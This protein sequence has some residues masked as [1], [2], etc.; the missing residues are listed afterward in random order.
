[1]IG[2]YIGIVGVLIGIVGG[3]FFIKS[4]KNMQGDLKKSL[5]YLVIAS[6]IYVIFSGIM[7]VFGIMKKD[8]GDKLWEIVPVLFAISSIFFVLGSKNLVSVLI[9]VSGEK[10]GVKK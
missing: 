2:W 6:L 10:K 5:V 4:L 8:I 7:V 1:M 9:G 3:L